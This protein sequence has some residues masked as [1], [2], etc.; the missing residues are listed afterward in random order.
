MPAYDR[1]SLLSDTPEAE[2]HRRQSPRLAMT[3][4]IRSD[5]SLAKSNSPP[6]ALPRAIQATA[7]ALNVCFREHA[8]RDAQ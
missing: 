2:L 1:Q 6:L 8:K 7:S 4:W 3:K 5:R